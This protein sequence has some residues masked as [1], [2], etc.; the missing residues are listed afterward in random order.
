MNPEDRVISCSVALKGHEWGEIDAFAIK[1][2]SLSRSEAI[3]TLI[4]MSRNAKRCSTCQFSMP[5]EAWLK[6]RVCPHCEAEVL[7]C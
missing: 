1:R 4:K 5:E 6:F 7:E 3:R 2:G